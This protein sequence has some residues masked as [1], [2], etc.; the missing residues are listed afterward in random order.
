MTAAGHTNTGNDPN[1]R[2]EVGRVMPTL[3]GEA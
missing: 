1:R 3:A 2:E